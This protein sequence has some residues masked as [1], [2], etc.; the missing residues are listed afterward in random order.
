MKIRKIWTVCCLVNLFFLQQ[1]L[2]ADSFV[3]YNGNGFSW[4]QNGKAYPILVDQQEYKGVLRAVSNLQSDANKVTGVMPETSNSVSGSKMLII[5]SVENSSWIKK[6]LKSGKINSADLV[7]K[8]EKYILQTV[9][10][11][12]EGVDEAVVI[13]GSDKR[14]TIYGI[15]ELS[16]QMGVSP[17]YYWADVPVE[18]HDKIS[19]KEGRYTDGEPAVKFRGIFLNDEAPS[20]SGWSHDTFGGFNSKFYE[21]VFELLLRLKGNFMWPAMWGNAF[22]DDDKQNGPLADEMGIV[23]G[24]SHH[25]PMGLAQQDWKRRG[26]GAWNYNTNGT[27]LRDFWKKGIERC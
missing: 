26:T 10:Q 27:V 12:F 8:R 2:A 6:L 1:L 25:E 20:L 22:Y 3:T 18:K 19:I 11:P 14:G 17:W 13:A 4:I 23:M 16:N 21:K 24:T 7:G 9:K 15:Y 5:G